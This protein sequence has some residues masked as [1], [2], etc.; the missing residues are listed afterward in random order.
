ML[1]LWNQKLSSR[2][3]KKI[4]MV[5]VFMSVLF[6]FV[7]CGGSD[8]PQKVFTKQLTDSASYKVEGI[9]ESFYETGRKRNEFTVFYKSPELIKV[10]IKSEDSSDKQIILKNADGVYILIPA[11]NKNFK[12]Q[13]DWPENASY[14]YLLQSL[15]KDIAN[16]PNVIKTEDENTV[17]IETETQMHTDATP[18]RQ[19]I[20]FEKDSNLPTE[21]LIYDENDELYIRTVFSNIELDYNVSDD[22]FDLEGS[23]TSV[24][25]EYTEGSI[26]YSDREIAYPL[27][28]PEAFSLSSE[29]T[30]QNVDGTEVL[31]V[32][33]YSGEST[34]FTIVQEFINDNEV[35]RY[36]EETGEVFLVLGNLTILKDNALHTVYKGV[37]YTVAS[38]DLQV[39]ELVKIVQSY[40]IDEEGK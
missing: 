6:V 31:S 29:N 24:R 39:S 23:M 16:D 33:K 3:L 27:Y 11:V 30:T 2:F 12:I 32:M 19:K 5:F 1:E 4:L 34:G 8:D 25:L 9:M 36:Q 26:V 10:V 22:E 17:T 20:I 15:A 40:M 13:S 18:V 28:C 21:V 37:E 7:G 38:K 35:T 14:P